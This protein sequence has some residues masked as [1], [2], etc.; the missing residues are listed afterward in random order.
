MVERGL[1]G[2]PDQLRVCI[3]AGGKEWKGGVGGVEST[4]RLRDELG[5]EGDTLP[6]FC[7]N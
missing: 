1:L 6:H 2:L 5:E 3:N 4:D 7:C